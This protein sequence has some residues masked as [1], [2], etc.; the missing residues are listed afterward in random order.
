MAWIEL[1]P[2]GAGPIRA[3]RADPSGRPRGGVVVVQEIF[4][5]NSHIRAVA[6]RFAADGY[7]A[8]A[9]AI[10][11][12]V[13]KGFDVGYDAQSRERGMAIMGKVDREQM[14]RDVAAAIE[15]AKEG[16]KVAAVGFCLG[17]TVAWAAAGR[18]SGLSAA[19]G[20]YGGGIIGL[21]DLKPGVPTLLHFG[22]KDQHIRSPAS[23]RSAPL[24]RRSRSISIRP[25]MASTATSARATTSRAPTSPGRA[26]W[27]SSANI[28]PELAPARLTKSLGLPLAALCSLD[29]AR[30]RRIDLFRQF[31]DVYA[32]LI[33]RNPNSRASAVGHE[34]GRKRHVHPY[35]F[36]A[37]E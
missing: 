24:T 8:F 10:F 37:L 27:P 3:W 21:K 19:V 14:L 22:D 4:G 11:E 13:E 1:K 18:L 9:P 5:V 26:R 36:P 20:Y 25:I 2:E 17:G 28:S 34:S 29:R 23:A 12:H 32:Y 30:N 7:L 33:A 6:D 35:Q 31:S 15:V 16:G